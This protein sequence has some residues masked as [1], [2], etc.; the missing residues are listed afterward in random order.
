MTRIRQD[1][2]AFVV[3]RGSPVGASPFS[4]PF[5]G[6]LPS[7]LTLSLPYYLY[8]LA[9]TLRDLHERR[10]LDIR[11]LFLWLSKKFLLRAS[12]DLPSK[13]SHDIW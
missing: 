11:H 5:G 7:L 2:L 10:N 9:I 1:C 8:V 6:T 3:W 13:F 4:A 12:P